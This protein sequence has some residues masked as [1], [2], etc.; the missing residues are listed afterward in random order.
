MHST[1]LLLILLCFFKQ[2]CSLEP[3]FGPQLCLSFHV[4]GDHLVPNVSCPDT[5][6]CNCRRHETCPYSSFLA[7]IW[8][9][10]DPIQLHLVVSGV[11]FIG[12]TRHSIEDHFVHQTWLDPI[13]HFFTILSF[14][15]T[16][17][18]PSS[19]SNCT[20]CTLFSY[21]LDTSNFGYSLHLTPNLETLLLA[22]SYPTPFPQLFLLAF[23]PLLP[24]V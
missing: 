6:L 1:T 11:P 13:L 4:N 18:F 3:S 7:S 23:S 20:I 5:F 16:C 15:P 21:A 2:K 22:N 17:H 12:E 10:K 19:L 9:S 24:S 8:G 14:H